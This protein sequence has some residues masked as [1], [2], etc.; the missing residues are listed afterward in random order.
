MLSCFV[1]N[2]LPIFAVSRARSSEI[3]IFFFKTHYRQMAR[4]S[5]LTWTGGAVQI[6]HTFF[7]SSLFSYP[8]FTHSCPRSSFWSFS[9]TRRLV[10][11]SQRLLFRWKYRRRSSFFVSTPQINHIMQIHQKGICIILWGESFC[12]NNQSFENQNFEKYVF[13]CIVYHWRAGDSIS[14]VPC[15]SHINW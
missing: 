9:A 1:L 12:L 7:P 5:M 2:T 10:T 14:R 6:L 13:I 15:T 3:F 11:A 4:G 8:C